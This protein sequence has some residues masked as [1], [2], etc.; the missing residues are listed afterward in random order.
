MSLLTVQA[1]LGSEP[2]SAPVPVCTSMSVYTISI[3]PPFSPV[4]GC[5]PYLKPIIV[6]ISVLGP[7]YLE[8]VLFSLPKPV[9]C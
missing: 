5:L 1:G 6:F 9:A 3:V 2:G 7:A 4:L 8:G